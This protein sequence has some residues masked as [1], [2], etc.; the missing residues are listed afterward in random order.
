MEYVAS[1]AY[2][3]ERDQQE[4]L[5]KFREQF[6]FPQRDGKDAIYFCGNS[7]GLQPRNVKGAI[8]QELTSTLR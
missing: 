5:Y 6:Y 3:K 8:E 7:L 4:P 2:A 1:L